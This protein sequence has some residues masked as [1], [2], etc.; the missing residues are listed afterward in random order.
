MSEFLLNGKV[1]KHACMDGWYRSRSRCPGVQLHTK[2][3]ANITSLCFP[4]TKDDTYLHAQKQASDRNKQSLTIS[5]S[6]MCTQQARIPSTQTKA[7]NTNAIM[8]FLCME[9]VIISST[10]GSETY[11]YLFSSIL[12]AVEF[13]LFYHS[14]IKSKKMMTVA[15][16][17]VGNPF[18]TTMLTH[19]S[20]R[21]HT[22]V[23]A[24]LFCDITQFSRLDVI[25]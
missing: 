6:N 13:I 7:S 8:A 4:L 24:D 11:P 17:G 18:L 10:G 14:G 22:V 1:L 19:F 15:P 20:L 2:F 25:I 16:Q 21:Y 5:P 23:W 3:E 12:F 9:L